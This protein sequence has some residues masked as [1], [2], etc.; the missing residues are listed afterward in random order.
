MDSLSPKELNDRAAKAL[1]DGLVFLKV[2]ASADQNG[3]ELQ[4]EH[5]VLA[6]VLIKSTHLSNDP[7]DVRYLVF[8]GET[9]FLNHTEIDIGVKVNVKTGEAEVADFPWISL[10]RHF[11]GLQNQQGA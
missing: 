6:M 11:Q 3:L 5:G 7:E 10:R 1:A 2:I 8:R 4:S 9:E